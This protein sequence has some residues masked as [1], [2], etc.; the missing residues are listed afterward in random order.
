MNNKEK[1][2]K[3]YIQGT[4]RMSGFDSYDSADGE[5]DYSGFDGDEMSAFD[6]DSMS[7]ASG[8]P[9]PCTLR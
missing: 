4:E 2:L 3:S 7:Y 9:V 6:G 8:A 1:Q 5:G